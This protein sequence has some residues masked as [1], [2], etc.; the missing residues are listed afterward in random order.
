MD[1]T[2]FSLA[3]LNKM[4][5]AAIIDALVEDQR[6][7]ASLPIE[8][9]KYGNAIRQLQRTK[10]AYGKVIQEKVIRWTYYDA[11]E[12]TVNEIITE[13]AKERATV[14]HTLDG[15]GPTLRKVAIAVPIKPEPILIER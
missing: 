15:E 4:T 9:D 2:Q 6:I 7:D 1:L 8:R 10:D 11:A 14:K 3:E 13:D 5:K 12:G